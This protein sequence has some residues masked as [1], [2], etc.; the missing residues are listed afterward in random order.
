MAKKLTLSLSDKK[1][2]GVCSGIAKYFDID[3]TIVRLAFVV[4]ALCGGAGA[5]GYVICWAV[6]PQ[7]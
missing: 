7:A 6:M 1:L 4:L 2:L 3:P 5:V